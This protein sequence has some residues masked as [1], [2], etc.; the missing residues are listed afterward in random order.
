MFNIQERE[1]ASLVPL[2]ASVSLVVKQDLGLTKPFPFLICMSATPSS[3]PPAFIPELQGS[4]S[5]ANSSFDFISCSSSITKITFTGA[6][7]VWSSSLFP[8]PFLL[9]SHI[10]GWREPIWM[11]RTKE[12][13]RSWVPGKKVPGSSLSADFMFMSSEATCF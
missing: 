5:A 13:H 2:E 3:L 8:P 4:K 12:H 11:L 6:N 9:W 10:W 1:K 7:L